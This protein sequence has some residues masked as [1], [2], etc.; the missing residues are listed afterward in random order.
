MLCLLQRLRL[1]KHTAF[2]IADQPTAALQEANNTPQPSC[3]L[4][5]CSGAEISWPRE[6]LAIGSLLACS[7]RWGTRRAGLLQVRHLHSRAC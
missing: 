5:I 4:A 3:A 6:T 2:V 1:C 7:C